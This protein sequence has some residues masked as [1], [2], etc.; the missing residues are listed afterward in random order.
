MP[1]SSPSS[2]ASSL[3]QA[4]GFLATG[5]PRLPRPRENP[6]QQIDLLWGSSGTFFDRHSLEACSVQ[7]PE[8]FCWC[9]TTH[10]MLAHFCTG[11][12]DRLPRA[13]LLRETFSCASG[14]IPQ[15]TA[16]TMT[17]APH[18][19][20]QLAHDDA[21]LTPA[22]CLMPA[23]RIPLASSVLA[24]ST[25]CGRFFPVDDLWSVIRHGS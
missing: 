19:F 21:C 4:T 5:P 24:A 17:A 15:R 12:H 8:R 20:A 9:N 13:Q 2:T 3:R 18:T 23:M 10:H 22:S 16:K 11:I 7:Q 6:S 25:I 1:L 14:G